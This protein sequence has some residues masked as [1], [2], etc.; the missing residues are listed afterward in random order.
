MESAPS[1]QIPMV[2][3]SAV[4]WVLGVGEV[5]STPDG[6]LWMASEAR[7]VFARGEGYPERIELAIGRILRARCNFSD[8]TLTIDEATGQG[9]TRAAADTLRIDA[10]LDSVTAQIRGRIESVGGSGLE[11]LAD[12]GDSREAAFSL[13]LE[14]SA[15]PVTGLAV[16]W[17]G[18]CDRDAE[19]GTYLPGSRLG[20]LRYRPIGADGMPFAPINADRERPVD[21]QITTA[22]GS[23]VRLEGERQVADVWLPTSETV[24]SLA[25]PAGAASELDILPSRALVG[26][27]LAFALDRER[28]EDG[29]LFD[30][31]ETT[32][33]NRMQ[34]DPAER[35]FGG[36]CT[37]PAAASVGLRSETPSVCI[38]RDAPPARA[39]A[40][41]EVLSDG[42]CTVRWAAPGSA[43]DNTLAVELRNTGDLF[44]VAD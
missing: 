19:R 13:T 26:L 2:P 25:A 4:E 16:D 23:N 35:G 31:A 14:V 38:L 28:L 15:T 5:G 30:A 6:D 41:L 22:D 10:P 12:V 40:E 33:P 7:I 34:V 24:V 43:E 3:A 36:A 27:E 1:L 21:L 17:P 32:A 18:G 42:R 44:D 8:F 39:M 9:V 11:C 20:D 29:Q 37:S